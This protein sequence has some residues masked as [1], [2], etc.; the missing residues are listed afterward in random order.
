MKKIL[1]FSLILI[2]T[3]EAAEMKLSGAEMQAVL[4]DKILYGK[5]IEQIFQKSGA[6]FY[7][8]GGSQSQG[9]WKIDGEKYCS[10]WPRNEAWA[11]Y[12]IMQ[13][14]SKITFIAKDGNRTEMS[15]TK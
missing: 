15:I 14:G 1:L 10:Q 11:C 13:D 5:D 7:S 8:A 9:N 6:T 2:S 3:A 4:Y 12:D